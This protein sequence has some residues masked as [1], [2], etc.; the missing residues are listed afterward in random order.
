M[1]FLADMG[2]APKTVK[3]LQEAGH[4]AVHLS[5]QGLFRMRDS[6][7]L[8]KALKEERIILTFDLDFAD[9]PAAAST[10]LPST[11]ILRLR[12]TKP[13]FVTSRVTVVVAECAQALE[14]GALVTIEDSRYRLRYLPIGP[15]AAN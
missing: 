3:S 10:V 11:I 1:K 4:N 14:T 7:I 15:S 8:Q 6:E 12:N 13:S 9:L 2:V 5:E